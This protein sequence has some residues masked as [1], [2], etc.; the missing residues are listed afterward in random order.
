MKKYTV[1]TILGLFAILVSMFFTSCKKDATP[2]I[3]SAKDTVYL[4][5]VS[6]ALTSTLALPPLEK[7]L[8]LDSVYIASILTKPFKYIS[9]TNDSVNKTMDSVNHMLHKVS[10]RYAMAKGSDTTVYP[11]STVYS[12]NNQLVTII[13]VYPYYSEYFKTLE[14][15]ILTTFQYG[16]IVC[17][18]TAQLVEKTH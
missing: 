18:Y 2:V 14:T 1:L 11:I 15:T 7:I 13:S 17:T 12:I 9:I 10:L 5:S 3:T 6:I 4:T 16:T 8:H